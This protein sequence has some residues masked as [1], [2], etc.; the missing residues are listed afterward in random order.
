M[1]QPV[2]YTG[3]PGAGGLGNNLFDGKRRRAKEEEKIAKVTKEILGGGEIYWVK[4]EG[5]L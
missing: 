1:T 5:R 3:Q 4:S 2:H